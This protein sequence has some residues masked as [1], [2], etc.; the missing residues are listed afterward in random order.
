MLITYLLLEIFAHI[1]PIISSFSINNIEVALLEIKTHVTQNSIKIWNS[2]CVYW[3]HYTWKM[4][5][6]PRQESSG[7]IWPYHNPENCRSVLFAIAAKKQDTRGEV[8]MKGI[9][10]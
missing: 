5:K 4:I 7:E 3:T 6:T 1:L 8:M 10:T 2:N 9:G